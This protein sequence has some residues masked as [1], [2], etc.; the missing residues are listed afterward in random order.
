M[1]QS[2]RLDQNDKQD[3][4]KEN[5]QEK[6]NHPPL[7]YHAIKETTKPNILLKPS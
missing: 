5:L 2:I 1:L 6:E 3:G 7:N 4:E